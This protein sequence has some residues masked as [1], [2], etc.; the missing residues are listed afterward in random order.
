M[1]IERRDCTTSG[2]GTTYVQLRHARAAKTLV[3]NV[4]ILCVSLM[5]VFFCGGR[6]VCGPDPRGLVL[7]TMAI[8]MSSWSFAAYVADESGPKII[9]SFILTFIVSFYHFFVIFN[10]K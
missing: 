2:P 6:L 3:K 5:Q 10:S 8:A 7:T 1:A 9:C 4:R